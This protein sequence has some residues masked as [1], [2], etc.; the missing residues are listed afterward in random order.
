[1]PEPDPEGQPL[2]ADIV[3]ERAPVRALT[4]GSPVF[5][6]L[7]EGAKKALISRDG[8]RVPL[9][10]PLPDRLTAV[11]AG[12]DVVSQKVVSQS[13]APGTIVPKGTA[14]DLVLTAPGR[15]PLDV[16]DGVHAQLRPR[17]LQDVFTT[18]VRDEPEV[19]NV[20]ARNE[21]AAT[22]SERD[23]SILL[24]V[25]Q[26]KNVSITEQPDAGLGGLFTA[27]QVANTFGP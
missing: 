16:F 10:K 7:G 25:A 24:D 22:L 2:A 19:R 17:L 6:E 15:I 4:G 1:M 8:V 14:V 20:L 21:S 26:R 12:T 18:F 3:G 11:F 27:L 13:I 9:L 5:V 23:R